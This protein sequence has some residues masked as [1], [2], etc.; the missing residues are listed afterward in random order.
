MAAEH[1]IR[2]SNAYPFFLEPADQTEQLTVTLKGV[3]A[4]VTGG[5]EDMEE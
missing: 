2:T 5:E 4:Q 3:T 1:G